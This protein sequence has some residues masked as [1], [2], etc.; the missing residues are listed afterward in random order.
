ML[1]DVKHLKVLVIITKCFNHYINRV[2]IPGCIFQIVYYAGTILL[3]T[4]K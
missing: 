1:T 4:N 2:V 3:I